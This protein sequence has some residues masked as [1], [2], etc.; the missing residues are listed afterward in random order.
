VARRKVEATTKRLRI[1]LA[2]IARIA[3][4]GKQN[5]EL[6]LFGILPVFLGDLGDLG[7]RLSCSFSFFSANIV[8]SRIS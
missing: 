4:V 6:R 1:S 3:K 8:Y 7:E 2:R 5:S